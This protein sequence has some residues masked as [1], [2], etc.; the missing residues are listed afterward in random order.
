[1]SK[2]ELKALQGDSSQQF[3]AETS[4]SGLTRDMGSQELQR[5]IAQLEAE[6]AAAKTTIEEKD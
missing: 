3:V 2:R 4:R 1:M 6:L 5:R